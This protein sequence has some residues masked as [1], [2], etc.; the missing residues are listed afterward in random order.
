MAFWAL[1]GS[2][3]IWAGQ[4]NLATA[5]DEKTVEQSG[6]WIRIFD[7]EI[8]GVYIPAESFLPG[9]PITPESVI[10]ALYDRRESPKHKLRISALIEPPFIRLANYSTKEISQVGCLFFAEIER[11]T[12]LKKNKICQQ[13]KRKAI[14]K[15]KSKFDICAAR[16]PVDG[17]LGNM[18]FVTK[19]L[20]KTH[21][22]KNMYTWG[23]ELSTPSSNSEYRDINSLSIEIENDASWQEGRIRSYLNLENNRL[24]ACQ[25]YGYPL[26]YRRKKLPV[27]AVQSTSIYHII[28]PPIWQKQY[29]IKTDGFRY[30]WNAWRLIDEPEKL[31][32]NLNDGTVLLRGNISILRVRIKDGSTAAPATL[33]K[34]LDATLVRQMLDRYGAQ[35]CQGDSIA[36]GDCKL[37]TVPH[38]ALRDQ[39]GNFFERDYYPLIILGVDTILQKLFTPESAIQETAK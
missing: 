2:G 22:M 13:I 8:E 19:N 5:T 20:K 38:P 18:L 3:D 39:H 15:L 32:I 12:V 26:T 37:A 21:C 6:P 23:Y 4:S 35:E 1:I 34:T 36:A 24:F 25:G 16:N 11:I 28:P 9:K 17:S 10:V 33:V 27:G 7:H 31:G 29:L 30:C 14:K